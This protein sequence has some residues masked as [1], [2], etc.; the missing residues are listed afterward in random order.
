MSAL[1]AQA[2]LLGKYVD[3]A[4]KL[5][6]LRFGADCQNDGRIV[7]WAQIAPGRK[8][9]RELAPADTRVAEAIEILAMAAIRKALL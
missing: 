6:G 4:K 8:E 5:D 2:G 7:I 3:K 9:K 1:E